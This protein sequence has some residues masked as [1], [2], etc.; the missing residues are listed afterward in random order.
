MSLI[1]GSQWPGLCHILMA[2]LQKK[3]RKRHIWCLHFLLSIVGGGLCQYGRKERC[4]RVCVC[5]HMCV[6]VVE[7]RDWLL[8]KQPIVSFR[9]GQT[10]LQ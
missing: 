7:G 4:V 5:A 2:L 8:T 10:E 1:I 6:H 3:S 9:I